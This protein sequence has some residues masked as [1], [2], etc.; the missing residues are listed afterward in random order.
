MKTL[1]L[2]FLALISVIAS[3]LASGT[4]DAF[5]PIV[6]AFVSVWGIAFDIASNLV[7]LHIFKTAICLLVAIIFGAWA[8]KV[9]TLASQD[10]KFCWFPA[11]ALFVLCACNYLYS[12]GKFAFFGLLRP[13]VLI[14][15]IGAVAVATWEAT[16]STFKT[17]RP[18]NISV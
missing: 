14:T 13:V 10:L 7:T 6:Y 16:R 9:G 11:L 5:V 2:W 15:S 12:E 1:V 8:K 18:P 3:L 17:R 4:N